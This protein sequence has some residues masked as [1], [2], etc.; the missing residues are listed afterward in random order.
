MTIFRCGPYRFD[1][2]QVRV[3]GILN[4][5]PDS[6][7]DGGR[8]VDRPRAL[9]HARR[10]IEEG[11]DLV[12]VGGESTRPGAS[13]VA[14]ADELARVIPVVDALAAEGI[15]VAVDTRKPAVMRAAIEAGAAMINDVGALTAAGAIEACASSDVGVCLM[16]MRGDPGTMQKAPAY[17]DVVAEVCDF[18]RARTVACEAGGI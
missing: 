13:P 1:L 7:F 2:S 12:D 15:A 5:T 17:G 18:L 9:D 8:F 10:M 3:M 4:V 16:H 11:A 14:E 6:F